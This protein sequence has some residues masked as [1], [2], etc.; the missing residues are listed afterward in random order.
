MSTRRDM[1]LDAIRDLELGALSLLI[2]GQ[3]VHEEM[4]Y[5]RVF[6]IYICRESH[7]QCSIGLRTCQRRG[8]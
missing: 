6:S 8:D 3:E 4:T 1:G 7:V 5:E 2:L